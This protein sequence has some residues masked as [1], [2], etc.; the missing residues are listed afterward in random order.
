MNKEDEA[1]YTAEANTDRKLR[2]PAASK[3]LYVVEQRLRYIDV[4][5]ALYGTVN[6]QALI[7]WFGISTPQ[8][9]LDIKKYLEIAPS[10]AVY[11]RTARTY[12]RTSEFQ[13]IWP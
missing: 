9:S 13:Q 4:L 3:L 1:G 2:R 7:M 5:L 12:R 6:R 8:A 10:N 11:D